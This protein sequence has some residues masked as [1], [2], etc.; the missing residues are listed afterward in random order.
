MDLPKSG[1]G[2]Y[3]TIVNIVQ[4]R[5]CE[6]RV[7]SLGIAVEALSFENFWCKTHKLM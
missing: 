3:I 5:L 7:I 4:H 2:L 6:R 1:I